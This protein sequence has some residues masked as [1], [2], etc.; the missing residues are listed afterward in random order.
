V[1]WKL[2]RVRIFPMSDSDGFSYPDD[3]IDPNEL[4]TNDAVAGE[5]VDPTGHY[6]GP[7]GSEPLEASPDYTE[8]DPNEE[9]VQLDDEP[10]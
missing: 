10:E 3:S 9:P 2:P 5:P 8:H 6:A 1:D 4:I 7:A